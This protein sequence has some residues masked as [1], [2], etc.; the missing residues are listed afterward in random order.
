MAKLYPPVI[1]GT[2]PAF[3]GT[4][5]VVPFSMNRSVGKTDIKGFSLKI[6]TIQSNTFVANVTSTNYTTSEVSFDISNLQLTE[7]QSYKLQ[8]AYIADDN[9]STISYYSSV[10]VVKYY[11]KEGPI[12]Y[13]DGISNTK[14]N[15]YTGYY[16]GVFEHPQEPLEKVSQYR[17]IIT[18][19]DGEIEDDTGWLSHN[20][21]NDVNSISSNDIYRNSNELNENTFYFLQYKVITTNKME[22]SSPKYRIMQRK[23]VP[24]VLD[25]TLEA[26]NN[27]DDGYTAIQ[28]NGAPDVGLTGSFEISRQ[29]V[30]NPKH[31]DPIFVFVLQSEA[32][33]KRV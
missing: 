31:W 15:F 22:C 17:F 25:I 4:T 13:I 1:E 21:I 16:V 28:I 9:Y 29:N 20:T 12:T 5:L 27:Y 8:L 7:G 11:G 10:G 30:K 33:L 14:S 32:P 6:K 18:S 24:T 23:S 26:K 3:Y 19:V 2:I